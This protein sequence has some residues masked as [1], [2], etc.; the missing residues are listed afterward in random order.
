MS[1]LQTNSQEYG[2]MITLQENLNLRIGTERWKK[3]ITSMFWYYIN[4]PINFTITLF[5]AIT[6]G[7][8]GA[9]ASFLSNG[10]VFALLFTAF[11]LSTINTF[12]KLKENTQ[13]NYIIA[14]KF[15]E[16]ANTFEE[17]YFT[18]IVSQ[19]DVLARLVKYKKLMFEINEFCKDTDIEQ[20]NYVSELFYMCGKRLCFKKRLKLINVKERLWVLDGR[21][22]VEDYHKEHL[23]ID[24][25]TALVTVT[26]PV[27]EKNDVDVLLQKMTDHVQLKVVEK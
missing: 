25:P 27:L 21:P 17:I 3:Y 24:M 14:Q 15:E 26:P 22:K 11:L 19:A 13:A 10:T 7:Q 6:S 16:F 12:F 8:V 4:M 5:T 2:I 1:L 18:P 9:N 20:N 23:V